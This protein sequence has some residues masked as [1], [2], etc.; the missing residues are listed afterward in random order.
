MS[1]VVDLA[2]IADR[3]REFDRGYLLT[4]KD[5]LVKA[6]SVRASAED[7]TL[8]VPAPGRGSLR[9]VGVN[10]AVTLLFPPTESRGMTLLV[11]GTAVAEG[12]DVRVTPT[13][14]VLHK[15][16]A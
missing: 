8:L 7:G 5:G 16:V 11:D 2:E 6:V 10:P 9:N 4:A 14:A 15:A 13:G 12:D 1:V 3:L